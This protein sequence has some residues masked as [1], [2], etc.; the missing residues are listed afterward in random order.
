MQADAEERMQLVLGRASRKVFD[1]N[2][3]I[4]VGHGARPWLDETALV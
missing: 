3:A 4:S 2:I 1:I